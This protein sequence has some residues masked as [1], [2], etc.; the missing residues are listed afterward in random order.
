MLLLKLHLLDFVFKKV[1]EP[2]SRGFC[3]P[4]RFEFLPYKGFARP[5]TFS[6]LSASPG[7][8]RRFQ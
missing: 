8:A 3:D 6:T 7:F 1:F 4:N 5:K 2:F